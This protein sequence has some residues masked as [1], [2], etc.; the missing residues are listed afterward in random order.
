[1]MLLSRYVADQLYQDHMER[2]MPSF[3]GGCVLLMVPGGL[4]YALLLIQAPTIPLIDRCLNWL[5][6][7]LLIPVWLQ[8]SYITAAKDYRRILRVFALG[9][10]V[11]LLLG[12][13]MIELGIRVVTSLMASM[14]VGYGIMLVGFTQVLL[15][16]FPVGSGS[17]FRFLEWFDRTP[18]L[19]AIGFFTMAGAFAH[20]ILMWFSPLGEV[21]VGPF[22]QASHHDAAAFFAYLVTIPTS[23][24]FIIS[25][26][27]T[28]YQ[29]YWN[30]FDAITTGG[31][32]AQILLARKSMTVVLKQEIFKLANVQI[33]CLVAYV[34]LMRYFLQTIGFTTEMIAMFQINAIGY[35]SYAIG[36]SLMLL[37][38]YFNDRKGALAS[39]LV[40][41]TVNCVATWVTMHISSLYYGVGFALAGAAFYLTALPRLLQYVNDID[42][43]VFCQQPVLN[44]E[45]NG[46]WIRLAHKLDHHPAPP[47]TDNHKEVSV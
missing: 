41:F 35:S 29:K 18:E 32:L 22:R 39:A 44:R 21:V 24:N 10:A 12:W 13:G 8:L 40:F 6:F 37:Q 47:H 7:M 2:V 46:F 20:L 30:Y 25:V 36:N 26:E 14:V 17:S 19:L 23:I 33:F 43:H 4:L 27:V 38:L 3:F 31:T 11:A 34:V 1:Q 15:R 28:F 42:Y 9:I 5:L 45:K 16:Y